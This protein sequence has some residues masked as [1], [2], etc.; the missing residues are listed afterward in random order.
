MRSFSRDPW[1]LPETGIALSNRIQVST[2][3]AKPPALSRLK[4]ASSDVG[5]NST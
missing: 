2:G 5:T 1:L 4:L 3:D